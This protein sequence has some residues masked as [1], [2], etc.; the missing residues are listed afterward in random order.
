MKIA[1]LEIA[2]HGH[3]PYVE[4]IAQVFTAVPENEVVIFTNEK[5]Q[6]HLQHLIA[7]DSSKNRQVSLI[8]KRNTEGYDEFFQRIQN[9]DKIIVVT[10]EAYAREPYM[11]M[12]AFNKIEFNCPIDYVVHNL[13]FWFQQS[14]NDKIK[15]IFFK[16]TSFK[17]FTYRLK[18]YFYY[19]LI[20]QSIISKVINSKGHF[21]TMTQSMGDLLAQYVGSEHVAIIPFSVFDDKKIHKTPTNARLRVCIPGFLSEAR[22]DYDAIF[23]LLDGESE[24]FLKT[25]IEWDFLGGINKAENGQAIKEKADKYILKGHK[26]HAYESFISMEDFDDNLSKADIILGNMHLQQ[27]AN[28]VYGK[29]KETGIIFTMIKAAKPGI[30]P[31]EYPC[32]AQLKSSVLTFNNY[33]DV[34]EILKHLFNNRNELSIL[35]AKAL[36]NALKF[37]PLSIYRQLDDF[38]TTE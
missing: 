3:Y 31:A 23:K 14:L 19:T 34:L 29:T 17:D 6:Q 25:H 16:L 18:V 28:S 38:K 12:Q 15:N 20:N 21:V 13:D 5:G 1:I 36:E 37:T 2:P 33:D 10:L 24:P 22:R 7:N 35:Q 11:M 27:G 9:F 4:S 32:D 8:I 30:L 26:I